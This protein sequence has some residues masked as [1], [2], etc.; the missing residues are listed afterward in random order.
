MI[1]YIYLDLADPLIPLQ[2]EGSGLFAKVI[3]LRARLL[4]LKTHRYS[5]FSGTY[6]GSTHTGNR[7]VDEYFISL[8]GREL[9]ECRYV[10]NIDSQMENESETHRQKEK[11]ETSARVEGKMFL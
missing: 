1:F 5:C 11:A 10:C 4:L 3:K 8:E 2:R 7:F 9:R 6:L